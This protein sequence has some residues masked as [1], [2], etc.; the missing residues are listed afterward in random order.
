MARFISLNL[1]PAATSS[2]NALFIFLIR[3][4]KLEGALRDLYRSLKPTLLG[5]K[6][7]LFSSAGIILA[8]FVIALVMSLVISRFWCRALCPLGAFYALV[9]RFAPFRRM[10]D[11]CKSCGICGRECRTGAIRKDLSYAQGECV[12]CMDCIYA[13]PVQGV[14]FRFGPSV[15]P[16]GPK[17]AAPENS[18]K[19][20]ISRKQFFVFLAASVSLLGFKRKEVS[21]ERLQVIRPPAALIEDEFIDRCVRCGNCMKVCITNGLQPVMF[22][23]GYDGIWTPRLVPEIGYCEYQCT[24]CGK[25]CPTGAIPPIRLEEK[26]KTRLGVAE[27]DRSLCLPYAKGKECIVC[28]EHCPVPEKAII[29]D[30]DEK[31]GIQLP[32]IDEELCVGC[33]ICQNK[34]PVRPV[35]AVR[36]S[37]R[38]SDR[39]RAD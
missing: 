13:C 28:Q 27:V 7:D 25:T 22:E 37:P 20:G 19:S 34:C 30:R 21:G 17:K 23:T 15:G 9:A 2:L 26:L 36:I 4:M 12:L 6:M 31:L 3:D 18:E 5:V 11:E 38:A 35:R 24:L 32:R 14:R 33:G 8:Y 29:L 1:I 16:G 10:V 39:T